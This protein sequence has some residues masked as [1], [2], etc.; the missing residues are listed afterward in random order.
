MIPA[1]LDDCGELSRQLYLKGLR[2]L[3]DPADCRVLGL[4]R[5]LYRQLVGLVGFMRV[6]CGVRVLQFSEIDACLGEL[7]FV[8]VIED[9]SSGE[10]VEV[11][12]TEG[13][14]EHRPE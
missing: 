12:L 1:A 4:R 3:A 7:A 9:C 2:V 11:R 5:E 13:A 14:H 6:K 8:G 10:V